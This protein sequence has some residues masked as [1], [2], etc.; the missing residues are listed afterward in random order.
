MTI[1]PEYG[2]AVE[3]LTPELVAR[4]VHVDGSHTLD[5]IP[6]ELD[7][8]IDGPVEGSEAHG[9][10]VAPADRYRCP[11]HHLGRVVRVE[12]IEL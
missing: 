2:P 1:D 5:V 11:R 6:F 7:E 12:V 4:C 10:L 8:F 9:I 3:A